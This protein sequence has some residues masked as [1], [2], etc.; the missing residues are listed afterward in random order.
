M[1]DERDGLGLPEG[2]IGGKKAIASSLGIPYKTFWRASIGGSRAKP[3]STITWC[4]GQ[5]PTPLHHHDDEPAGWRSSPS[6]RQGC[7]SGEIQ[8]EPKARADQDHGSF[9]GPC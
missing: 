1:A 3:A 7:S 8:Q 4:C 6:T 9:I 5:R 2:W